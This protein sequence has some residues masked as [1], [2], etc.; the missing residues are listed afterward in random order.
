MC[1][2]LESLS[3]A[4]PSS[5]STMYFTLYCHTRAMSFFRIRFQPF[6][7]FDLWFYFAPHARPAA[8]PYG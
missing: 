6:L 8:P 2:E 5:G 4:P 1:R 3:S 7:F